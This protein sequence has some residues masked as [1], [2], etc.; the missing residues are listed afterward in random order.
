M[1][2]FV[3]RGITFAGFA[4][5][6]PGVR[7]TGARRRPRKHWHE[8]ALPVRSPMKDF[9]GRCQSRGETFLGQRHLP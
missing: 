3:P 7:F 4:T 9:C 1:E 5:T 8:Q 6:L 2:L